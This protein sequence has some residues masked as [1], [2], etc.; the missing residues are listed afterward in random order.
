MAE[1][2]EVLNTNK[3][4]KPTKYQWLRYAEV[5]IN[6]FNDKSLGEYGKAITIPNDLEI[7]FDFLR[8]LM[9]AHKTLLVQ[10]R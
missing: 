2:T 9:I 6:D 3:E 4:S 5:I 7:E 1:N 10:S 8:V